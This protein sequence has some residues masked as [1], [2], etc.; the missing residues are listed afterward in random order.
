MAAVAV[1]VD[2]L[3]NTNSN[4]REIPLHRTILVQARTI[5]RSLLPMT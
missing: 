3:I 2:V 5:S 4:A 1:S